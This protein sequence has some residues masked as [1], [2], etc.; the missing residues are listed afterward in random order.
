MAT[1]SRIAA[2]RGGA[3][4]A[5]ENTLDAFAH[6]VS[7]GVEEVELD[8]HLSADG[9]VMVHHDA[10]VDR[11]TDGSGPLALL[12]ARQLQALR[13]AG[14]A[15]ATVPTLDQALAALQPSDITVRLEI[16][17]DPDGLAYPTMLAKTLDLIARHR[18]SPRLYVSAFHLD[19][20][21]APELMEAGLSRMLLVEARTFRAIGGLD[22]LARVIDLAK[23]TE[24]ALPIGAL[25]QALLDGGRRHGLS[26]SAF[27]CHREHQIEA[28]LALRLPVFTTDRPSL[29]LALRGAA[30]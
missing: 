4:E 19:D 11:M 5:P 10:T 18:L 20:L 9:V 24:V 2:H 17:R 8:I 3:L 12:S 27:G 16:K 29:A 22:G 13:I 7:L 30:R 26:I 21:R 25:D 14:S 1:T 6:A 15:H 23:I 28:A